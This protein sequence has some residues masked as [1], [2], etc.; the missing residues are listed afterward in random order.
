MVFYHRLACSHVAFIF[1]LKGVL[2]V[3][4]KS[5]WEWKYPSAFLIPCGNQSTVCG[6]MNGQYIN[7]RCEWSGGKHGVER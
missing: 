7:I 2:Y 5:F 1:F 4:E 6:Q 3:D